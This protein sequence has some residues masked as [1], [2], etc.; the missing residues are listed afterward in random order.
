[1]RL[2]FKDV[3]YWHPGTPAP[4]FESLNLSLAAGGLLV[5]RGSNGAG[6]TTCARLLA[7]LL[8]PARG[9]ILADGIDLRQ[10]DP[11]WWRQQLLYLP[12]EPEFYDA[13]LRDN[14]LAQAPAATDG[15]LTE[16]LRTVGL[17]DFLD[18]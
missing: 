17:G 7:G 6:K 5:I 4:L 15:E 16:A 8:T 10:L 3:A 12:Q 2:E 13:S 11:D 1:G 9:S 18:Q 14:L